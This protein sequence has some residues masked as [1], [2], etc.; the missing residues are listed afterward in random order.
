MRGSLFASVV[1]RV[2]A[3]GWLNIVA[4]S[5]WSC[6]L[7]VIFIRVAHHPHRNTVFTTYKAA[8]GNWIAA[9]DLYTNV[10]GFVYS[11]LVAAFFA[12][13][14]VLPALTANILWRLLNAGMLLGAVWWWLRAGL[15][16]WIPTH[17]YGV[18]FLLLLPLTI[19]NLNNGQANPMLIGLLMFAVIGAK[20]G[21]WNLAAIC[22]ALAAYF[23][24]YPLV[25][26]FL[27]AILFPRKFAWRLVIA[28]ILLGALTFL[29]QRPG[30]VMQEYQRWILT[31]LHDDR[32]LYKPDIAPRDLWLLLRFLH[33]PV[34]K[35]AY[36]VMQIGGGAAIAAVCLFGKINHWSLNRLLVALFTL[37]SCWMLLLGPATE[38]ATYV[39]LAPALVLAFVEG[40]EQPIPPSLRSLLVTALAILLA[41]LCVNSFTHFNREGYAMVIQPIGAFLFSCY[42]AIWL[43]T[44][45]FWTEG[46]SSRWIEGSL[47]H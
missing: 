20:T 45:A 2:R 24:I 4:A 3:V 8:G 40:L 38:S 36:T 13:F 23:K 18:V 12:P 42:A 32:K 17:R 7:I 44:T 27:L 15:H 28:L 33:I 10:G 22:I 37:A 34:S 25:V 29:L 39:L 9:K 11:P 26:G 31:R 5:L 14:S 46:H 16:R 47:D 21:R 1:Q 35:G 6:V 41:A 19:G 43:L 30:F